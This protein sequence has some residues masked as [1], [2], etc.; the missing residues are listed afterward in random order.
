MAQSIELASVP[1][2]DV[3]GDPTS[4]RSRWIRWKRSFE[5]Y[6]VGK[7]V[8]NVSQ[9]KCLLL[10]CAG[11]GV[12]DIFETLPQPSQPT[13]G[14]TEYDK[15]L[16]MLDAYFV[17][18]ANVPFERHIFRQLKQENTETVDQFVARLKAQALNCNFGEAE[19]EQLRDQIID[20]CKSTNLRRK[21]L[22]KGASLTLKQTQDV[23]RAIE[24]A[25]IQS[26]KMEGDF[27]AEVNAMHSKKGE[28]SKVQT[29]RRGEC[30]RCGKEGH[31]G[32]DKQCPARGKE[33][34]KCRK[35]GHFAKVCKTKTQVADK[36]QK[37]DS[38]FSSN[39]YKVNELEVTN[40]EYAFTLNPCDQAPTRSNLVSVQVGGVTI[41]DMLIDSGA[42]CNVIDKSTWEYLKE[43]KVNC[44]S[45]KSERKLYT[46]GSS[47]PLNTLGEFRALVLWNNKH[48]EADFLVIEG[49]GKSILGCKTSEDLE[50][51]KVGVV[52]SMSVS[53]IEERFGK[54]FVGVGKLDGFQAK[55]HI[56][57]DVKPVAQ[58]QRRLP[59]SMREKVESKLKEL[60]ELDIIEEVQGPTPWVSPVV[61]VPK[62]NGEVR[63]CVD[64]RQANKAIVR[65]RHPIPTIEEV[66]QDFNQSTVF[67]K[68]DL[69][70]GFHQ[71]ELEENSRKITTFATHKGLF[72]YKRL[73]F[74]ISSAPEMYQNII[75]QVL[76]GCEGAH[77]IADDI[78]IHGKGMEDHDKKLFRVL[79]CIQQ[80]GLTCNKD[81]CRF[82]M[83][84]L[85][86]MGYLLSERGIAPIEARIK[87]VSQAR[88]PESAA[89]VRSFL[90]LVNFSARFLPN[91]ATTAE[92]LRKLTRKGVQFTWGAEQQQAF[93]N[94]KRDL[95]NAETLAYFDKSAKTKVV[96]DAS[97]VGIG[98]ILIQEKDGIDRPVYYA[99][100][101]LTQVERRYS[102][103]EREALAIVWACERFSVYLLG[104][105]FELMT[106]HKPLEFIYSTNSKPPARIERWVLRLQPYSFS[107]KYIPGPSNIADALSRLTQTSQ[108]IG[109][110]EAEEYVRYIA[111]NATPQAV[112]IQEIE[113]ESGKDKEF[114][115]LRKCIISNEWKDCPQVY[116]AVRYEL[117]TLGQLILRGTRLVVPNNLRKCITELSHEGHQG[118]VK[119]KQRLRSKVWWPKIDKD[120][121]ERCKKCHECQLVSQPNPPEPIKTTDLPTEPWQDVA[122]DLL[123]PMPS[124]ENVLVIVDYFSRFYEIEIMKSV[125]SDKIID[126]LEP[127][128]ARYGFPL[129]VK[130]DNGPQFKSEMFENYL[131]QNGIEHRKTTPYW[132]QANGEVE[133]Q[134]R[135]LLKV[136]RIAHAKHRDWKQELNKHLLAYRSTP[137]STTGLSPAELMF[138][139]K[140][141][142]KLPEMYTEKNNYFMVKDRDSEMKQKTKDYADDRRQAKECGI[143]VGDKVLLQQPRQDKLTTKYESE[144]YQVAERSGN[145]LVIKSPEGVEYK[146]N[147]AHV[148]RYHAEES[149]NQRQADYTQL[150]DFPVEEVLEKPNDDVQEQDSVLSPLRSKRV[151][152][153]PKYLD[154]YIL[155]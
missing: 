155:N 136:M 60:I 3:V 55:L 70:W 42:T 48:I 147:T 79:E 29:E 1:P 105:H 59:F 9:K 36:K 114:A 10:H 145:Q 72:Q 4:L 77:N 135:S 113:Q 154:D 102:Q 137:H 130:T 111:E 8:T 95:E 44:V 131:K 25:E 141:R 53:D 108:P 71:I 5:Y 151:R 82:R 68:L 112:S 24:T 57:P 50:V 39:N 121:E 51:L 33:C 142:T 37:K 139:R 64:M 6:A 83:S 65:E 103:T 132:P 124:G 128:F 58:H 19:S 127:I 126:S 15:A 31:Y 129:S 143:Q 96:T 52:C 30:Y 43:N 80:R 84:H 144:P 69:K 100:R 35:V 87:A 101:S 27:K 32:R 109:R 120:I 75:S 63:L 40:H 115:E 20:K 125:T 140:I 117:C 94:L 116:K 49:V 23:A 18:Q 38:K 7:G 81:K 14:E 17:P 110:N 118:I 122:A 123:G 98:A 45:K 76:S 86:F 89:E 56:D 133:R 34:R 152:Q 11:S 146:R 47:E 66:L 22:E 88:T 12:Q 119:C 99:S 90:G 149:N 73:M 148:R 74:G 16:R 28:K 138:G 62:D 13:D 106:D 54:C 91:L 104:V 78:I 153:T 21:L 107:V 92:P 150:A 26:K 85:S 134:N 46:Y 97:P 67:S 61:V 2:F 41:D 93:Q